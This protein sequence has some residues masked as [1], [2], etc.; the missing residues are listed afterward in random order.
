MRER[1]LRNSLQVL[2]EEEEEYNN[3]RY[4]Q[5]NPEVIEDDDVTLEDTSD[6]IRIEAREVVN[7]ENHES[8]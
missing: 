8:Q 2:E 5:N 4:V 7:A 1:R 6:N 3:S